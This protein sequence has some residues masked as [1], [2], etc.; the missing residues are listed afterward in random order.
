[1]GWNLTPSSHSIPG[2]Y[3]IGATTNSR[4]CLAATPWTRTT[5]KNSD[6]CQDQHLICLCFSG[7]GMGF[8][9]DRPELQYTIYESRDSD[10]DAQ[11]R[12]V[13]ALG[14]IGGAVS[15]VPAFTFVIDA[16]ST[17]TLCQTVTEHGSPVRVTV[18]RSF[19]FIV[20]AA[21]LG[22]TGTQWT[23]GTCSSAEYQEFGKFRSTDRD[24]AD[25]L[26]PFLFATQL[27]TRTSCPE[28]LPLLSPRLPVKMCS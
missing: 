20:P 5:G 14:N 6:T 16:S 7:A 10:V 12:C 4:A 15:F 11:V 9:A 17:T 27:K 19:D 8:P 22:I 23:L 18:P 1:M 25:D 26:T 3:R 13:T 2:T 24:A 21:S 28:T